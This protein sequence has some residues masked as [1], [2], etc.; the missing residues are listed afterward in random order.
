MDWQP[1]AGLGVV[2]GI[3]LNL[4]NLK[5]ET[6]ITLTWP[7][8]ARNPICEDLSFKD[9]TGEDAFASPYRGSPSASLSKTHFYKTLYPPQI[10]NLCHST[11]YPL[12]KLS[13]S[14]YSVS[15]DTFYTC[16]NYV[17]VTGQN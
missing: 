16:T 11:N 7:Q 8:N 2:Q 17:S 5:I 12:N 9:I 4:L 15:V 10:G 3:W 6:Y 13:P 1:R 14:E